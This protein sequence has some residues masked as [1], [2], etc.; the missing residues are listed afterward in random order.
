M[1][2]HFNF[3][4]NRYVLQCGV[5]NNIFNLPLRIEPTITLVVIPRRITRFAYNSFI[6]DGAV[7]NQQWILF[8][9][10]PPPLVVRQ[11]PMEGIHF[12]QC[13]KVY[14]FLYVF[15][16]VEVAAYIQMHSPPGI[17]GSICNFSAGYF[18]FITG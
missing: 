5:C 1:S 10:N 9:L 7:F 13:Q 11:V 14:V 3:G 4:N 18:H 16:I 2:R 8:Y 17:T 12:A 6:P 15:Y